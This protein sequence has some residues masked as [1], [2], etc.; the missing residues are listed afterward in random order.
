MG[1]CFRHVSGYITCNDFQKFLACLHLL[2]RCWPDQLGK[3]AGCRDVNASEDC[4]HLC[5]GMLD[6]QDFKL[7][8]HKNVEVVGSLGDAAHTCWMSPS[9]QVDDRRYSHPC[10]IPVLLLQTCST[11]HG[12]RAENAQ[13]VPIFLAVHW[14]NSA[15]SLEILR[16]LNINKNRESR[17]S[18]L[19]CHEQVRCHAFRS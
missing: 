3:A 19:P 13:E 8:R 10:I 4:R 6:F 5:A 18:G 11:L 2:I 16:G 14:K 1:N 9:F 7:K 12:L 17:A 15:S